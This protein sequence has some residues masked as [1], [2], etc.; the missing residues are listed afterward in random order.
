MAGHTAFEYYSIIDNLNKIESLCVMGNTLFVATI[1]GTLSLFTVIYDKKAMKD[2]KFQCTLFSQKKQFSKKPIT[3][4]CTVPELG[5]LICLTEGF[6]KLYTLGNLREIDIVK[7]NKSKPLNGCTFF[8]LKKHHGEFTMAVALKRKIAILQYFSK[9]STFKYQQE[10]LLPDA[11]KSIHWSGDKLIVGFRK[12]YSL[13]DTVNTNNSIPQKL[14]DTGIAQQNTLGCNL[15]GSEIIVAINNIGVTINFNGKPTRSFGIGWTEIPNMISYLKP[16]LITPLGV[17]VEIRILSNVIKKD[18]FIQSVPLQNICAMSQQNFIDLD[19]IESTNN[20]FCN[21][22]TGMGVGF[23]VKNE[24]DRDDTIDPENRLFLASKGTI[25]ILVMKQF[26]LQ[27]EELL[28]KQNFDL[29][30]HLCDIVK[31]TKYQ[32]EDWRV[33]SIHSQYGFHLF[34]K[35]EFD[36]AMEHFDKTENDPRMIISLFPDL[37]PTKSLFKSALPYTIEEKTS[38]GVLLKDI[39]SRNKALVALN[40]YLYRKRSILISTLNE[41]QSLDELEAIDTALLKSLLYTNDSHVEE[42]L[43]SPN[44]CNVM[45]SQKILH[46]HQK[47]RELVMFYKTKGLHDKALELLKQLGDKSSNFSSNTSDTNMVYSDLMGVMPTIKYLQELENNIVTNSNNNNNQQL[48]QLILEFSKWVL[49]TEPLRGL[50][51]FQVPKCPYGFNE[52]LTHLDLFDH[53]LAMKIAY[54]EHLIKVEKSTES[55][56]HNQ[57][58]LFY[59]EYVTK[60]SSIQSNYEMD[61]NNHLLFN[62]KD[63]KYRM[64]DFL[65]YSQ[66]YHPEKMLSKFPFDSLYEERAILLSKINRH[67]QALTI[68]VTKI[69]SIEMAEKYC[70]DHYQ[71]DGPE[72]S[73]EIFLIL[74]KMILQNM[75][76][77]SDLYF[78]DIIGILERHYNRIDLIK[79]LKLLPDY[80]PI[81]DLMKYFEAI[82]RFH[83]E[84]RRQ[85][86]VMKNIARSENLQVQEQAIN[87]RKRLVKIKSEKICPVCKKRIGLSA[88]ACYPNG[89]VTHMVCCKNANVCPTTLKNFKKEYIFENK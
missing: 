49:Q 65:I 32:V 21:M 42:F 13:I 3:Q 62:V 5:I 17:Y 16:Y 19:A 79:V 70:E 74:L 54:L 56:L 31:G 47:F 77:S 1:D 67:S 72:E 53:S 35:G 39:E 76:Q 34:S 85:V 50:K 30:L 27:A 6:I 88:F 20:F 2:N 4:M 15:P 69:Q 57:L 29:A 87:E 60:Y 55:N 52:I 61:N 83:T 14:F 84:N 44:Y 73:K 11:A 22:D 24:L 25:Y 26:D 18:T 81:S 58:L 63:I 64:K 12:E 89:I 75:S 66:Y 41:K 78:E 71:P 80:V 46:L 10:L 86:Q 33:S 9:E 45:D 51:I 40:S 7:N 48:L 23:K 8:A 36:K 82:L 59:L 28:M 43:S 68:Y 38:V 37:L